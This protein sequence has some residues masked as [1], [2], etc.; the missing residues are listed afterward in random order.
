MS[1]RFASERSNRHW[2]LLCPL[3]HRLNISHLMVGV[4]PHTIALTRGALEMHLNHV[5]LAMRTL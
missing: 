2:H 5:P 4:G 1:S 3:F